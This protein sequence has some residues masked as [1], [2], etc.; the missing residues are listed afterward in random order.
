MEFYLGRK[1]EDFFKCVDRINEVES[2]YEREDDYIVDVREET[3]NELPEYYYGDTETAEPQAD[4]TQLAVNTWTQGNLVTQNATAVRRSN[5]N[6]TLRGEGY[7]RFNEILRNSHDLQF[8]MNTSR[9]SQESIGGHMVTPMFSNDIKLTF[10]IHESSHDI[11]DVLRFM[12][13]KF[14]GNMNLNDFQISIT[15]DGRD[16]ETLLMGTY[17]QNFSYTNRWDMMR[18]EIELGYNSFTIIQ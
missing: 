3:D 18:F 6:I 16:N 8:E 2:E 13:N 9:T 12:E 17:F 10:E 1:N 7:E 11:T 5:P 14:N 4:Y 15:E